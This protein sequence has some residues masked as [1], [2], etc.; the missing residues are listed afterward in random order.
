[1]IAV[2]DNYDSFT[3]NLVQYL[4]QLGGEPVQRLPQAEARA[5]AVE[6]RVFLRAE[7]ARRN[8]IGCPANQ[9]PH[10]PILQRGRKTLAAAQRIVAERIDRPGRGE[11]SG[12]RPPG[13]A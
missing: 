13:K 8:A 3:W 6:E 2:I 5:D 11:Q 12:R 4:G 7:P 1:M 10:G 9:E